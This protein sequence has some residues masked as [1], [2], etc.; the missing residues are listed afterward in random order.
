MMIHFPF[1]LLLS[2]STSTR[3]LA[4][5]RNQKV[6][7]PTTPDAGDILRENDYFVW[8]FNARMRLAKK[9]LLE[10]LDALKAPEEGDSTVSTWK[11]NGMKAFSIVSTMISTNLQSMVCTAKTTVEA[12]AYRRLSF[13]DK[14]CTIVRSCDGNY[15][16]SS[17]LKKEASWITS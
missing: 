8:E 5:A 10:Y 15:M 1:Y 7:S 14:V 11:A 13:C 6:M 9:V 2:V 3:P 16:S 17:W 12:W 4:V